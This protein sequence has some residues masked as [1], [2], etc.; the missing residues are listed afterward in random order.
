MTLI[1]VWVSEWEQPAKAV[2]TVRS[3]HEGV[4]SSVNILFGIKVAANIT[5]AVHT[6]TE[7]LDEQPKPTPSCIF[8][9]EFCPMGEGK[10]HFQNSAFAL[11]PEMIHIAPALLLKKCGTQLLAVFH[12]IIIVGDK[13]GKYSAV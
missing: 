12:T 7:V 8:R 9:F 11:Q 2:H 1:L 10:E 5:V 6:K 13:P 4:E 3:I